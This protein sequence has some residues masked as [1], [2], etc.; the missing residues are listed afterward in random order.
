MFCKLSSIFFDTSFD[1]V[2]LVE[3]FNDVIFEKLSIN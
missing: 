1:V 2:L 3:L